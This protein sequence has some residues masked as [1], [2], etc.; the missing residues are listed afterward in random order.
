VS[1]EI[2]HREFQ[3]L[4]RRID[5]LSEKF[6]GMSESL[7][8]IKLILSKQDGLSLPS[9]I[10]DLELR[11]Q[12]AEKWQFVVTGGLIVLQLLFAVVGKLIVDKVLG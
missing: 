8:D 4:R 1:S 6:D 3:E 2:S 11:V 10:R 12:K 9:R 5:E 7:T